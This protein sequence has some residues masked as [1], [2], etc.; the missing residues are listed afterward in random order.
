LDKVRTTFDKWASSGLDKLMEKEHAKTVLKFLKNIKFKKSF[1]FL[2]VGCGNGWVVR[3]IARNKNCRKA[4]G[5]DKSKN[6]IKN[7][8]SKKTSAKEHYFKI[9]L[10]SWKYRGKFDYV[11]S[12]ESLYYSVPMEPQIRKIY[13]LIKKNGKFFCGT[14]FY[15]E[16][17]ATTHWAEKMKMRLDLRS[18]PEWKKMFENVGFEVVTK[19]VRDQTNSKKWKREYGTLFII[20]KKLS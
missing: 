8:N 19:Q 1:S 15:K 16:N 10:K 12:M 2:D 4:V 3:H 14:D 20:G 17:K 9:D 18:K 11:F 13:K 7:A 5:I 6:M